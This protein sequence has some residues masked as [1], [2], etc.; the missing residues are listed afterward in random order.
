MRLPPIIHATVCRDSVIS[1]VMFVSVVV[2]K[3][4]ATFGDAV[5]TNICVGWL[6]HPLKL[7]Y[8]LNDSINDWVFMNSFQKIFVRMARWLK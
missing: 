4:P 7:V 3:G 5:N 6:H 1:T 2:F 8:I